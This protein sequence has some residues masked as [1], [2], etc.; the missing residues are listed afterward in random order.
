MA[1]SRPRLMAFVVSKREAAL[2]PVA[3]PE[4]AIPA[5]R[6]F[7]ALAGDQRA[8]PAGAGRAGDA[9]REVGDAVG[10]G[11]VRGADRGQPLTTTLPLLMIRRV[12]SMEPG[13]FRR[14]PRI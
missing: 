10:G 11:R 14:L 1:L 12:R 8:G 7:G 5:S 13:S 6:F 9:G 4:Q 3:T 2:P